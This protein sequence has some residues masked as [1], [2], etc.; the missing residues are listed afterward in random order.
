MS[1]WYEQP[2]KPLLTDEEKPNRFMPKSVDWI[3]HKDGFERA[4]VFEP[5]YN[6]RE[7]AKN[8][9]AR[10]YGVHGMSIRFLLRGEKGV[11]QFLMNTGWVPAEPMSPRVADL[12][13]SGFDLGYHS[14]VEQYEGM[15][16]MGPCEYL[17]GK[18]CYYDGSGLQADPVLAVFIQEGADGVWP[19]LE[20]RYEGWLNG[21]DDD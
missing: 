14:L 1:T 18:E 8:G 7:T 19:L 4:V 12:Y 15:T 17:D 6:A 2:V 3:P 9:P 10:N 21:G 20:E 16:S 5:G 11:I 13:P